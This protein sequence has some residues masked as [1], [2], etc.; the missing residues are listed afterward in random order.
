[1]GFAF[2]KHGRWVRNGEKVC[3]RDVPVSVEE[4]AERKE[5]I[6]REVLAEQ[7]P[8]KHSSLIRSLWHMPRAMFCL[9]VAV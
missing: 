4:E 3:F 2:L 6:K 7:E 1:M 5:R 8:G 9:C